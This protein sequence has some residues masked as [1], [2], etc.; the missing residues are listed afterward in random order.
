MSRRLAQAVLALLSSFREA[1]SNCDLGPAQLVP[2]GVG[3]K[4]RG[5][6]RPF[7]ILRAIDAG[8]GLKDRALTR[9]VL[10]D[11]RR[12]GETELDPLAGPAT[13]PID[14]KEVEPLR[15]AGSAA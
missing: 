10:P 12:D 6:P 1:V 13:Q 11:D 14:G 8:S 15:P 7:R 5:K 2:V 4:F 9:A 3:E